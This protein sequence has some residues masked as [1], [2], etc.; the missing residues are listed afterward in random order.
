MP[1]DEFTH[2][3]NFSVWAAARAA[4]RGFT[5][6]DNLKKA[7]EGCG[8]VEYVRAK[9]CSTDDWQQYDEMHK[10]WCESIITYLQEN[11]V[12]NVTYGRA[13]KLIAVYIKSMVV[14]SA[15]GSSIAKVAHPPIDRILLQ[16]LSK[17][18]TINHPRKRA[19]SKISWTQ[20]TKPHY[21]K[22]ISELRDV[23]GN[24]PFW[25]LEEHWTVTNE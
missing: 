22:L 14:L 25:K 18:K 19:W 8:V 4:Q 16:N 20:L 17:E 12:A 15:L 1:Y 6:V 13:A 23:V 2:K 11:D 9:E 3:H 7:L 10:Q 5:T 24:E 21:F